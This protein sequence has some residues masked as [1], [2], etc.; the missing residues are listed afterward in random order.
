MKIFQFILLLVIASLNAQT[1]DAS[2]FFESFSVYRKVNNV[3]SFI[4]K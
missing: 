2:A 1:K 4:K 3:L